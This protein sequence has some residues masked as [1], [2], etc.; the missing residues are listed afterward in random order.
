[1][2]QIHS[3]TFSEQAKESALAMSMH[4]FNGTDEV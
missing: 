2:V 4:Q 1:M 3:D